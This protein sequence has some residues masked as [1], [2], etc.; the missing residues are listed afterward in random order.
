MEHICRS[1]QHTGVFLLTILRY[2]F[3]PVLIVSNRTKAQIDTFLLVCIR[4]WS[5]GA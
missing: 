2:L 5:A 3:C 4:L 1:C